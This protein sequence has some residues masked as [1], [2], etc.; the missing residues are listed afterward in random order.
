MS[1]VIDLKPA[2]V[3]DTVR[4][5][6]LWDAKTRTHLPHR[7]FAVRINAHKAALWLATIAR[8]GTTIEVYDV[9]N[10]QLLGQFTRKVNDVQIYMRRGELTN[11]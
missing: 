5:F 1:A 7:M 3:P 9:R 8:V 6:R 11:G 2:T 4:P 10:G